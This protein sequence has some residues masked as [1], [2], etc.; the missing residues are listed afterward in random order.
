M[1]NPVDEMIEALKG[2]NPIDDDGVGTGRLD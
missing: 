1:K 2:K